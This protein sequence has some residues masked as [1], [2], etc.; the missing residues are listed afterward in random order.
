M[1]HPGAG[2]ATVWD[3]GEVISG[4]QAFVAYTGPALQSDTAY[5]FSVT[6]RNAQGVWSR[7][8]EPEPFVTGLR[9]SDWDG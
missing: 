2:G 4:R 6:T 1:S 8:S 7:A 3:S 5:V 9:D